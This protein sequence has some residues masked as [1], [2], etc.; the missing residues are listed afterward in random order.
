[1]LF[2]NSRSTCNRVFNPNRR[3]SKMDL[4][5]RNNV[6][7]KWFPYKIICLM[8]FLVIVMTKIVSYTCQDLTGSISNNGVSKIVFS[9]PVEDLWSC[10]GKKNCYYQRNSKNCTKMTQL[11]LRLS[12]T[13]VSGLKPPPLIAALSTAMKKNRR[14]LFMDPF[15]A[16]DK[17]KPLELILCD[18]R[19]DMLQWVRRYFSLYSHGVNLTVL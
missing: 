9:I 16:M 13:G 19:L 3:S 6:V 15:N 17:N 2:V 8:L 4:P 11:S 5:K 18:K 7:S 10:S 14:G 12:L 1:R